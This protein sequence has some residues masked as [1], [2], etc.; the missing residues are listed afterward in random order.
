MRTFWV[1]ALRIFA[2]VWFVLAG[3]VVAYGI[4]LIW[5]HQGF[6]AVQRVLSSLNVRNFVVT[7]TT[8]LPGIAALL[9]AERLTQRK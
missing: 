2:G 5:I 9:L 4:A 1:K 8:F 3:T 6:D 7:F